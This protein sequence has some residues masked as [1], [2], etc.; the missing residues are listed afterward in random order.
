MNR[1]ID[2]LILENNNLLSLPGRVFAPLKVMRLMLRHNSLERLSS[3]WLMDLEDHLVEVYMV[4]NNLRSIP[5]DSLSGLHKL[6]AV[7]I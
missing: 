1:P 6:E 4:E 2:E 7:T 5:F 3:G